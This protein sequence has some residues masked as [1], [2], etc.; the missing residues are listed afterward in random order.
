MTKNITLFLSFLLTI[1]CY[2]Q[3]TF[4]I[5]AVDSGTGYIGSAGAT[6]LDFE[7]GALA[8]SDIILNVGAIHT[9]AAYSVSNQLNA[10]TRMQA[11]DSPENI[12][13]WLEANDDY[14]DG[15]NITDRQYGVVDLNSGS[16]RSA[17]YTGANNYTENGHRLGTDYSIQGNILISE[18][19]LNDME[20]AFLNSSG[21][22]YDRLMAVMQAAK[23]PGADSRCYNDNISSGSA[24]IRVATPSDTDS[25]YGNL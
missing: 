14:S 15:F 16:P 19:V 4:S 20:D 25:S 10:R 7:D 13:S 5:V 22:L 23:R 2:S 12:I 8:I 18:D 24:F 11:G 3:H 17:A 21:P 6:C 9:Q 1:Y